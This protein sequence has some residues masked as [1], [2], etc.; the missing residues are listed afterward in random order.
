MARFFV[1]GAYPRLMKKGNYLG[2]EIDGKWWRRYRSKGFFARG[3]GEFTM[4]EDGI[5]FLRLMTK[6][7]LTIP[8]TE[9]R[10]A[11]L[12]KSH[13]GRWMLGRPILKVGF[14]RDG[15]DLVAGFYLAKDWTPMEQ[16]AA[17]L[18]AKLAGG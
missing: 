16:L 13:A 8:W 14:Q 2:T 5:H 10:S 3:N 18:Q 9:I 11:T 15:S 7:P 17:D 1:A 4:D 12:G 6:D